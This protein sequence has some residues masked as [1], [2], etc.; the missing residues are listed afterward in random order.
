VRT[1]LDTLLI[2]LYVLV[3]DHLIP[4]ESRRRGR[5]KRLS[6]AEVVCLAVAEVLPGPDPETC[7]P[8][9]VSGIGPLNR[10]V[11]HHDPYLFGSLSA[12]TMAEPIFGRNRTRSNCGCSHA[13][14]FQPFD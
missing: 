5:P 10:S 12:H 7:K 6:D 11:V 1:D 2:A 8:S 4:P 9:R 14:S 3:D 13:Q